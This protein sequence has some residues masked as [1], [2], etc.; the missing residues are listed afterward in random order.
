MV[1]ENKQTRI[2]TGFRETTKLNF[3]LKDCFPELEDKFVTDVLVYRNLL[4]I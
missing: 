1:I 3:L 2:D 4:Y